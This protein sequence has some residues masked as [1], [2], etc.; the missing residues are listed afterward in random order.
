MNGHDPLQNR[1]DYRGHRVLAS[2]IQREDAEAL[3]PKAEAS[4]ERHWQQRLEI[5]LAKMG[6]AS[7]DQLLLLC[8]KRG[9]PVPRARREDCRWLHYQRAEWLKGFES[10]ENHALLRKQR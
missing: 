8:E 2:L 4:A 6:V 5:D 10:S 7:I 1:R 9:R 3:T